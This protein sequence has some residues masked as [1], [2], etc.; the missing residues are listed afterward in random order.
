MLRLS[1]IVPFL[2]DNSSLETTLLALLENR[3]SSLEIIVVHNGTYKDPYDLANDEVVML[4]APRSY[5]ATDLINL[6]VSNANAPAVQ[7]LFPGTLV[8]TE[9]YSEALDLLDES[10]VCVGTPIIA[11]ET[12]K[13]IYG[14][15]RTALPHLRLAARRS[16]QVAPLISGAI[17]HRNT[18]ELFGGLCPKVS[19]EGAEVELQ[20]LLDAMELKTSISSSATLKAPVHSIVGVEIGYE[21]GKVCGQ[22]ACAYGAVEGSGVAVDSIAKQLSH[23]AGGIMSPKS[24]AERLGWVMGVRDRTY[25]TIVRDRLVHAAERLDEAASQATYDYGQPVRRAA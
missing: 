25:E 14:L 16:S 20:L 24:V 12:G 9:W 21:T 13:T 4:E 17:F 2:D 5:G 10:V 7:V 3:S 8:E 1:I 15:E 23:L 19:R 11:N 22:I 6:A 18:W